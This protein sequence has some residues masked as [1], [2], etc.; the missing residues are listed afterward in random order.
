M[1][2]GSVLGHWFYQKLAVL[3]LLLVSATS[4]GHCQTLGQALNATNLTWTTS[5]TGGGSGWTAQNS[6]TH[7][8]VFAAQSGQLN[9][10]GPTSTLQTITNGPGTVTFWWYCPSFN[11]KLAVLVN[12][13]EIWGISGN[14]G[15][16]PF[17]LYLG[18]GS[19]TIKWVYSALISSDTQRGYVDEVVFTPGA[20]A[21][22][23]NTQPLSQSQVP[24]LNATFSATVVGTPPLLYQWQFNG[25]NILG[26]TNASFTITNVQAGALGDYAVAI[27][28]VAGGIVSSSA[29]LG[30]G[31][32]T[33]WGSGYYGQ[34][35]VAY[36]AT[37]TIGISAGN[38]DGLALQATG[39]L[40]TWGTNFSDR[41]S[42]PSEATNL[43]AV[44]AGGNTCLGLKQDGSVVAWGWGNL[45]QTN[46][47][48]GL[49]NV[50]AISCGG[51]HVLALRP[52]GTV[53]AWGSNQSGVTNVPPNL[54][55]V[56]AIAASTFPFSLALKS[57]GSVVAWGSSS[58]G[59]TTVP[60]E[61][62]NVVAISAGSSH[63][64]A[65]KDDGNIV[66]WGSIA[67]NLATPP[68]GLSNVIAIAAGGRHSVA[69]KADGTV[70]AWGYYHEGQT[71]VPSG[72]TNVHAISAGDFHT[73]ALVGTGSPVVGAAMSDPGLS[74]NGFRVA[75]PS[76]SGRVY[77]L[78]YKTSLAD[79]EWTALPLVA[80]NGK[81]LILTD[82]SATDSRRFY[83]VRRW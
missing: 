46:V 45:G 29:S 11:R 14:T 39:D 33:A 17:T 73:V 21:P 65:L 12:N 18:S 9:F 77:R 40:L 10:S 43:L 70:V 75:V 48:G 51:T 61:L 16:E 49:T 26:A 55:N 3:V 78:E 66:G 24:G 44:S 28:N 63:C 35:S 64:L 27:T 72:L 13:V 83:R 41:L 42:A 8:G 6:I 30:L 20:T 25:T 52:D 58:G 81:D 19:Q 71:N 38:Y 80:G 15:W 34:T 1:K 4:L 60:S 62:T 82:P 23:I 74:I 7:D 76:Q 69:L 32:V 5:G 56:V 37:N 68:A 67:L 31:N 53:I 50:A 54:S 59:V 22:I 57:D 2:K 36:G 47:P 79:A